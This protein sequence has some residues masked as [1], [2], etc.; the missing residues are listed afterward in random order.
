MLMK[1]HQKALVVTTRPGETHNLDELNIALS[2]GWRVAHATAMGGAGIGAENDTPAL[3]FAALVILERDDDVVPDLEAFIAETVEEPVE[4]IA[5]G[6]G[7]DIEVELEDVAP[8][9]HPR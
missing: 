1:T 5:E 8:T 9:Q 6:D 4:E 2:R 3:C 7:V